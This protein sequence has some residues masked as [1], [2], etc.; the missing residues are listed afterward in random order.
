VILQTIDCEL[1]QGH[2]LGAPMSGES[3]STSARRRATERLVL[4]DTESDAA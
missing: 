1:G 2:L 3:F 4:T